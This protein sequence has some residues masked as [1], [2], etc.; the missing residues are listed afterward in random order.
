M[1]ISPHAKQLTE[2]NSSTMQADASLRNNYGFRFMSNQLERVNDALQQN[3][4]MDSSPTDLYKGNTPITILKLRKRDKT[5]E[6][7]P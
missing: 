3:S 5:K 7:G 6:L 4:V 1:M 2:F